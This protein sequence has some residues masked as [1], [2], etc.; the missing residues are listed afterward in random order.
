MEQYAIWESSQTD[1]LLHLGCFVGPPMAMLVGGVVWVLAGP[2]T[3]A[4]VT[5]GLWFFEVVLVALLTSWLSSKL[6]DGCL[7]RLDGFTSVPADD[8][9]TI[10]AIQA[11]PEALA[12]EER[13][14]YVLAALL[15][16]G[17][18]EAGAVAEAVTRYRKFAR[19]QE[20]ANRA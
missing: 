3:A 20:R 15:S 19:D 1:R 2:P 5:V 9:V 4:T 12:G 6:E 17:G 18:V 10:A 16:R 8:E 14:H 13:L 11:L 7:D